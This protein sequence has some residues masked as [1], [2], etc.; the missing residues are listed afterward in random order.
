LQI[1]DQFKPGSG[2]FVLGGG[3]VGG[4]G[5]LSADLSTRV[6]KNV[7]LFAKS[8]IDTNKEFGAL[9]GLRVTW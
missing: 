2:R 1:A 5:H 8:H 3:V 6:S 4:V 9:A 7:S